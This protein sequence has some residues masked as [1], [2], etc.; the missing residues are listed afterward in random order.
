MAMGLPLFLLFCVYGGVNVY[1]PVLLSGLGY[2]ASMIG[3]LQGVFEAAGLI[4]PVFVSSRVDRKGNYGTVMILLGVLMAAILPLLV[5]FNHFWVAVPVLALFAIGFKGAV[6]VAD[7]LVSRILGDDRVNYGKVRVI[8]SIGFVCIT[9]LFQFTTLVNPDKPLSIA[10]WVSLPSLLF[11]LSV[12]FI[13]GLLKTWPHQ[14]SVEGE[15]P[16]GHVLSRLREFP[17]AFWAGIGLIFLGFLGMTPYQRFFSLYVREYLHLESYAGL[18]ALSAAAEVP[19][20]F[21]SGWFIRKYGTERILVLS[22][23]AIAIRNLVYAAFPSFGGAVAGQLL[24]AICFGLFH[25][26]AIVFVSERAPKRLMVVGMTLYSSVSVGLASVLGNVMGGFIID[27]AG[28]IPLFLIFS[29]FPVIGIAL[30]FSLK[31]M[32]A[33][34]SRGYSA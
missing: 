31:G 17:F 32:I 11:A 12:A 19:F 14:D 10:F 29:V 4:F 22:L 23:A 28:Y 33:G 16:D 8:G 27:G 7:A 2:S 20:M 24:H 34:R 5:L 15:S 25:P 9:L 30:F 1:L 6:P 3:I 26:A 18:W 13:P 21:L